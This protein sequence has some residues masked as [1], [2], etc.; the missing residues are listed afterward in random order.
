MKHIKHFQIKNKLITIILSI[1]LIILIVAITSIII[2]NQ[3][4]LKNYYLVNASTTATVIGNG[5]VSIIY[6]GNP[7]EAEEEL[8]S[9]LEDVPATSN[10]FVW[11]KNDRLWAKYE[12]NPEEKI[13]IPTIQKESQNEF[14]NNYLHIYRPIFY[15]KERLGTVYLRV[16]TEELSEMTRNLI[17]AM[18]IIVILLLP[19]SLFLATWLQGII[20]KPILNLVKTTKKV[21]NEGNYSVRAQRTYDD[22]V[23]MLVDGFNDMMEQ[24]QN[25]DIHRD[26]VENELKAAEFFLSSVLESMP[27]IIITITKE[28]II[29]HWNQAAVKLTK[30]E[31]EQVKGKILWEILPGFGKYQDVIE[32]VSQT[33]ETAQY[34]K[35]LIKI[36]GNNFFLN[37]TIFPLLTTHA[38]EF[39]LMVDN[40]TEIEIKEQQLRQSQ[41]M[42]TVGTLAGGLAHDFNNVLGGIIG[43]ISLYKYKLS[44]QRDVTQKEVEKYFNTIEESANRA[45]DMVQHLLS[46]TKKQEFSFIPT[47]LNLIIKNTVKICQNTFDKSIEI[48]AR[49]FDKVALTYSDPT[50]LEQSLLNLCINA[51]HAMTVMR[52]DGNKYG[53]C[54]NISIEEVHTDKYFLKLHP[55]TEKGQAYWSISVQDTGVGMNNSTLA[56][57]FDPFFTKGKDKGT[58]LGLAMVYN[59]IKQHKG[60]IDVYSQENIGSTFNIYL[61]I[62]KQNI[63]SKKQNMKEEIQRGKGLILVVDD[64]EIIRQTAKS[65][66][67]ECGYD[68]IL[69]SNG[70][71]AVDI[72]KKY[73]EEIKVI[74]L[75]MVMPKMSGKQAYIEF[76]KIKKDVKVLL[77]SGFKKDSRVESIMRL[78]I[79]GFIQKPYALK[80]LANYIHEVINS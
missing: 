19:L 20:S 22:E 50:Q 44:K 27:S 4:L 16:S 6:F 65:I 74:L 18:I 14:R 54:L 26:R 31:A 46:L 68:V 12:R 59:I 45:S 35:E 29:S 3:I 77:A 63:E 78:G 38:S 73:Q 11:D 72:F 69:A 8:A 2:F 66:L 57:I 34:Y 23:G 36:N 17:P 56:K 13:P 15:K 10:A 32:K 70:E 79:K 52:E 71:E 41:K 60:F 64:E 39:V 7:K 43:T 1:T 75:D 21:S 37:V 25:R 53:G 28:G 76:S 58:G 55:E 24:I 30:Q 51:A 9:F 49:Y 33:K 61:P 42:E 48:T 80:K 5:M 62:Y 40:V 67:N 47:D